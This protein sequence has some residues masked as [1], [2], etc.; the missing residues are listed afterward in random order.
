MGRL[1]VP[2]PGRYEERD[3]LHLIEFRRMAAVGGLFAAA[4]TGSDQ[5]VGLWMGTGTGEFRPTMPSEQLGTQSIVEDLLYT[6]AELI[7]IGT[8]D[9]DAEGG[10]D[11]NAAVWIGRLSRP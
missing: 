11:E 2:P 9:Y 4:G 5:G 3:D 6:G 7:A 1:D 8:S 10:Y